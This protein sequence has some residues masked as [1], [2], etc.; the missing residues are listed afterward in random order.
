MTSKEPNPDA[1]QLLRD[2]FRLS[3]QERQRQETKK[4]RHTAQNSLV[5]LHLPDVLPND[6][7]IE[8]NLIP[9]AM[10]S[11][12]LN[13]Q[14]LTAWVGSGRARVRAFVNDQ[15]SNPIFDQDYQTPPAFPLSIKIPS[16]HFQAPGS[17]RV[18]YMVSTN[19]GTERASYTNFTVDRDDP[20]RD[21]IPTPLVLTTDRVTPEY[22]A[23]NNGVPYTINVFLHPRPGDYAE[24]IMIP[25]IGAEPVLVAVVPARPVAG[26]DPTT[27]MTGIIARDKFVDIN[28]DPLYP[29]G[30]LSFYYLAYSRAGNQTRK[31]IDVNISMAFQPLPANLQNAVIPLA[32]E[33]TPLIDRADAILGVTIQI[34]AFDNPQPTD[35]AVSLWGNR[36][37]ADFLVGSNPTFPL[38]SSPVPYATLLS[39]GDATG[40]GLKNVTATYRIVRGLLEFTPGA[41]AGSGVDLRIPGP[42]NPDP[43]PENP[44]LGQVT[45]RGGGA[46]PEDNRIRVEDINLPV[47]VTLRA[48]TPLVAGEVL[49]VFW[50]KKPVPGASHTVVGDETEFNITVPFDFVAQEG[51]GPKIIV[52]IQL[53][54]PTLP[55]GNAPITVFTPV[56]VNTFEFGQLITPFFPDMDDF[57]ESLG[58]CEQIWEGAKLHVSGDTRNFAEGDTA[59]VHWEGR[60][61]TG[62]LITD[63]KG[64]QPY[65]L[66]ADQVT[67]GFDHSID[68]T[69]VVMPTADA[70]G[71][72][73]AWYVLS[74]LTGGQAASQESE[75]DVSYT[76][77][78]GCQCIAEGACDISACPARSKAVEVNTFQLGELL[79]P[80]FP[81]MDES[82]KSLGCCERIWE[83]AKLRVLGDTQNFGVGNTVTVHWEGSGSAGTLIPGTKGNQ[84]YVL[85]AEQ[86]A[87][88]FDHSI[89]FTSVV[90]PTADAN[91]DLF[92]WYVLSKSTGDQAASDESRVAVGYTM[93]DGCQCIAE[94]VCDLSRCPTRS[95][96]GSK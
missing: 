60:D 85:T 89:D 5:P 56:E 7:G 37:V 14:I 36:V 48:Y 17:H 77:P 29:D 93:P 39:E 80:I 72:L 67:R 16:S 66:T 46:D 90:R 19:G 76:L 32:Q 68:F 52:Y 79:T 15:D 92:A 55:P 30:V 47:S 63:T 44:A 88:G 53:T 40:E 35:R 2:T 73:F 81:D 94:G 74:K 51:D 34:P 22:L 20:N 45:V 83:G 3:K 75:V 6:E 38:E 82:F 95:K 62:T 13:A 57:F 86:V 24:I 49:Q 11:D 27:P 26:F 43:G 33:A 50:N 65:V 78:G 12:D 96:A 23:A 87:R 21:I 71:H 25:F 41:T 70:G 18:R 4:K 84:P 54:S 61:S 9:T 59:T 69:S 10:L 28:D 1:G 58:C 91:G 64:N 31:P 42:V 8:T